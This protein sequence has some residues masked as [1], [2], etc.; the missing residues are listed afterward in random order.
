MEVYCLYLEEGFWSI[1]NRLISKAVAIDV[2]KSD[3]IY[4]LDQEKNE[5]QVFKPTEFTDLVHEA[6]YLYQSGRYEKSK[7]PCKKLFK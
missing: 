5:I 6:L 3:N 4:V 1:E 2:D 7:E